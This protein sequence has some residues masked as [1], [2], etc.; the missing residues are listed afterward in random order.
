MLP[1]NSNGRG[2]GKG[3]RTAPSAPP[4]VPLVMPGASPRAAP[5]AAPPARPSRED[6]KAGRRVKQQEAVEAKAAAEDRYFRECQAAAAR[7][8]EAKAVA[9][10]LG[11]AEADRLEAQLFAKQGAQGIEFDKYGDIKVEVKGRDAKIAPPIDGFDKL[12]GLPGFLS[13]NI[14]LMRYVKPTP[15]QRHAVPLA[16]GG[17]DL[18]C[19]AQTGSGKTAAFLIPVCAALVAA[20]EGRRPGGGSTVGTQ[21]AARPR[22]V[23]MAP[24]RELAS[25]IEL[26]GQK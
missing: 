20:A 1:G 13:R 16:L 5:P 2:G 6:R 11:G 10:G 14:S 21:G 26:E 12:V 23:V 25:Q 15:I 17:A 4:A 24:T 22:A 8:G 18:M 19:C 9:A 3:G 7:S